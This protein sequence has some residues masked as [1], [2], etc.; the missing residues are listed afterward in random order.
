MPASMIIALAGFM[1]KVSGRSIAIVAGGPRPGITPITVP[2]A[3]PTRH[4]S[5]F[6][7]CS[8]TANPCI[9]PERTSTLGQPHAE[10]EREDEVESRARC[11]RGDC[12]DLPW[13]PVHHG[14]D[15]ESERGEAHE[16]ASDLQQRDRGDEGEPGAERAAR[17]GPIDLFTIGVSEAGVH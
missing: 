11:D 14:D 10:R 13:P 17:A 8:A 2:S 6:I 9:S 4:H 1:R 5:R 15:E 12:R 3:T 7:G 16:E